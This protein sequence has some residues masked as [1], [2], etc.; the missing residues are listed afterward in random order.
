MQTHPRSRRAGST[1]ALTSSPCLERP[2]PLNPGC[3]RR[4]FRVPITDTLRSPW[5]RPKGLLRRR[6]G[7][8]WALGGPGP[9]FACLVLVSLPSARHHA[10]GGPPSPAC[11][12]GRRVGRRGAKDVQSSRLCASSR[13]APPDLPRTV[14]PAARRP[15]QGGRKH[16]RRRAPSAGPRTFPGDRRG[17]GGANGK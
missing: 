17:V 15:S 10:G 4:S 3:P 2:H 8:P 1:T 14:A 11:P 5:T 6:L 12:Q 13:S 9:S 7:D 16:N